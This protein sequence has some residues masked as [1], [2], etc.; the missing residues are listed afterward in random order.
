[1]KNKKVF[2]RR[3][4][5]IC[6]SITFIYSA[7]YADFKLGIENI[8]DSFLQRLRGRSIGLI[9]NQTGTDQRGRRNIDLLV[10]KGLR[11]TH[12]FAPEH[13]LAGTVSAGNDVSNVVDKKTGI[14][15]VSLYKK[16]TGRAL[17]ADTMK[18]IDLLIFDI[19]DSGMRHYTY[20]STLLHAIQAAAEHGKA[21]V[22]LDRPN[23]LGGNM[24]G[25]LVESDLRSF[26][27]IAPIPLRHGMTIGELAW[28][29]NTHEL[30]KPAQLHVVKMQNYNRFEMLR[31][32]SFTALSP[33][34]KTIQACYGYSFLGLLGEIE[35]FVVGVHTDKAFQC[36]L[37]PKN[38]GVSDATWRR[39]QVVVHKHGIESMAYRRF[40]KTRNEHYHGL[41]LDIPDITRVASFE[42]LVTIVDFFKKEGIQLGFSPSFDKAMGTAQIQQLFLGK[43]SRARVMRA[44]N[45]NLEQFF[46]KN[47]KT[48]MYDPLPYVVLME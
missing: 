20:I 4:A 2:I 41:K 22:V 36:I 33:N 44:I 11:I 5:Q 17:D 38:K 48:F 31:V 3:F 12:I 25:P 29:F 34:I 37:L 6:I 16:G 23:P 43:V 39:L 10:Q 15:V 32:Q 26:I 7:T 28:Y 35:P 40:S 45:H 13:G 14:P 19:Q 24:E 27:S 8:S 30:K 9:T 1:M 18:K 46:H 21:I 47:F 42:L